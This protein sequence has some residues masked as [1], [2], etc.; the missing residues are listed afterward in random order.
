MYSI[1]MSLTCPIWVAPGADLLAA[2]VRTAPFHCVSLCR[3]TGTALGS[4]GRSWIRTRVDIRRRFYRRS[5]FATAHPCGPA[6]TEGGRLEDRE[7]I[8]RISHS[9]LIQSFLSQEADL[10][11][12][13]RCS[14]HSLRAR[15]QNPSDMA[16]PG[17]GSS[18]S[19]RCTEIRR[20]PM[21]LLLGRVPRRGGGRGGLFVPN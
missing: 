9:A 14:H 12:V 3:E 5:R 7:A 13:R 18:R 4:C 15:C 8:P 21:P 6:Q 10:S 11:R 2:V 16:C 17:P 1:G 19:P 20:R